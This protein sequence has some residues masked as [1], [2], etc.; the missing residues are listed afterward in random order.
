[1]ARPKLLPGERYARDVVS[2]KQVACKWVRLACQRHLDD[3][4]R[5]GTKPGQGPYW[6]DVEAA[7]HRLAVNSLLKH[8]KGKWAGQEFKPEPWQEF[9]QA[10]LFGWKRADGTRRFRTAYVSV[11]R[12]NGKSFNASGT[13]IYLTAFDGE[14]GAEVYSAATKKDQAKIVWDESVK[15]VKAS[16]QLLRKF[17]TWRTAL[18]VP[19][20]GSKCEPLGAD[21]DTLD[22]LNP[23]GVVIDELH[24]HKTRAVLDVLETALGAREQPLLYII[25][26]AG[27]D[28]FSPCRQEQD[29]AEN[30]LLGVFEDESYFALI[31]TLD[32]GDGKDDPGDDWKD[33]RV[34]V[35]AN[36]NLGVSIDRERFREEAERAAQMPA[37]LNAFLRLRLN[38]WTEQEKRWHAVGTW[39]ACNAPFDPDALKG[40]TCFAGL[41]LSS[42]TDLTAL[43]LLFPPT[44]DDLWRI[45]PRFYV[46][47]ENMLERARKDRVPYEAW[48]RDGF[49]FAT[50]GNVVDYAYI[51]D[52]LGKLREFYEIREVAHDR[53]GAAKLA[54]ELA[55]DGFQ[56]V[57]FGQG[58]AS[59]SPP[60]KELEKLLLGKKLA[61]GGHPVLRWC[62][63]N[64]AVA[65]DPAENLKP[66]K[67]KARERIDGITALVMA[68]GRAV[69]QPADSDG[70]SVYEERGVLV[71]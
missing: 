14:S 68:L 44:E 12:K 17:E 32:L 69:V 19:R 48:A 13:E 50:P 51:R 66:D 57:A 70:D 61:H 60:M 21:A 35:K 65:K 25:T 29:Y 36:P 46:P 4:A 22:G 67:S 27:S 41:D 16:P 3:L 55:G 9:E 53:W 2:G 33:E 5:W 1:M 45:L 39:D 37:K 7:E 52:D 10:V 28:R 49:L 24:A 23:H 71:L 43:L 40:A 54:T 11:A 64:L 6:F 63:S 8:S 56:M 62:F 38:V 47:E 26:T 31:Y 59:M 20:T 15:M 42:T 58:F 18:T 30:V 34:W